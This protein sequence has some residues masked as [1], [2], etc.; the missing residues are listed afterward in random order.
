MK[1]PFHR[2]NTPE[3]LDEIYSDSIRNGWLT[4][5]GIVKNFEEQLKVYFNSKYVVLLNSCT[6]GLHLSLL[7]KGLSKGDEFILPALTFASTIECGEYLGL[8]PRIIDS[9]K[10]SFIFDLNK[11]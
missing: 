2:P 6:A 9:S 1:I 3:S 4:T 8:R 7:A 5:G 10:E 11:V